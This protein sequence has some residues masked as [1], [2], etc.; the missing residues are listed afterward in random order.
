M[1]LSA[2][3]RLLHMASLS[4]AGSVPLAVV[5]TTL[6]AYL[7][8]RGVR[9][10][11]IGNFALVGLPW[12]LKFLWSPFIDRY[13]LPFGGRRRG[14][15]IL[16]ELGLLFT[17]PLLG[18]TD[19]NDTSGT[20]TIALIGLMIAFLSATQD[21]AMDAYAV[22]VMRSEEHA[23]G[24]ALRT[25]FYRLGMI[26][27]GA[28]AIA[29]A[30]YLPWSTVFL[31]VACTMVPG[32]A[33]AATAR[34]PELERQLPVVPTLRDAVIVP[35]KKL[36]TRPMAIAT[37][38]FVFLYKFGDN[39]AQSV[40]APFFLHRI[41]MSLSEMGFA[42]K[43]LG[44][45]AS[46]AG[47]LIGGACIP[48]LGLHRALWLFGAAQA[49]SAG[50]YALTDWSDGNRAFLYTGVVLEY[51][52][53]GMSTTALLTLITRICDKSHA[54]TQFAI[55][56][57][58]FALGRTLSGPPSGYLAEQ[59]GYAQFFVLTIFCGLPGLAILARIAPWGRTSATP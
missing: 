50:I 34:E 51:G 41:G 12:S 37:F 23:P 3:P 40:L 52:F 19:L 7:A 21:I 56:T 29:F 45:G 53:Q 17:I 1:R 36:F 48:K 30:D 10:A 18:V 32:I 14:F 28:A 26:G 59:L 33:L 38:C 44:L 39:M 58:I 42:Q 54:A 5:L 16:A 20:A 25:A 13:R 9:T 8:D 49:L 46:I 15:V 47:T 11:N 55:L 35:L 6:P 43:T 22:E 4:L 31:L 24:N 2:S 27:A 57:S